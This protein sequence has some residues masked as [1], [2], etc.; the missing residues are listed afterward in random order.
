[1]TC[2]AEGFAFIPST[3]DVKNMLAITLEVLYC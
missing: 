1:L 2:E 3:S